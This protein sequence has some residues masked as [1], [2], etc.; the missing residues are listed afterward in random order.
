MCDMGLTAAELEAIIEAEL[1][2][3]GVKVMV[4]SDPMGW[5][6]TPSVSYDWTNPGVIRRIDEIVERLRGQY[7]LKGS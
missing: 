1:N 4:S 7:D 5:H 3:P 6:A 2:E